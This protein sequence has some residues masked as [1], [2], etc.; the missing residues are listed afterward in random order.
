M[1]LSPSRFS[2]NWKPYWNPE[3]P[4]PCTKMRRG[5]FWES[6][7]VVAK[8][9][10]FSIAASVRES[11]G[12]PSAVGDIGVSWVSRVEDMSTPFSLDHCQQCAAHR[13]SFLIISHGPGWPRPWTL[14]F[15]R[16]TG[17]RAR[18]SGRLP[19]ALRR[20]GQQV[21]DPVP[22][23]PHLLGRRDEG[24]P[25]LVYL[26]VL[27]PRQGGHFPGLP[28]PPEL[29]VHQRPAELADPQPRPV[30]FEDRLRADLYGPFD[31]SHTV[32]HVAHTTTNSKARATIPSVFLALWHY[33]LC[34][35]LTPPPCGFNL[36]FKPGTGG[37]FNR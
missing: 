34:F 32:S 3:H 11:R 17:A 18:A 8:N 24:N 15:G 2:S 23:H 20:P 4:P 16:W 33:I 26:E 22:R 13:D 21:V 36:E 5:L 37:A 30:H 25:I 1:T 9:L 14:D 10:T 29:G 7:I 28:K 27:Q 6:G 31:V 35:Y 12:F 19:D